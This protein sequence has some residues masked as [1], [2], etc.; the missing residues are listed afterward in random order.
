[1][2]LLHFRYIVDT[3]L[4]GGL[5]KMLMQSLW[6]LPIRPR[7]VSVATPDCS[8]EQI[9]TCGNTADKWCQC[10]W[11]LVKQPEVCSLS[12]TAASLSVPSAG[13]TRGG[14]VRVKCTGSSK[15]IKTL[16]E[17]SKRG[18]F[19][20]IFYLFSN[21]TLVSVSVCEIRSLEQEVYYKSGAKFRYIIKK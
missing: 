11:C 10:G 8:S 14:G 19:N 21:F 15:L 4:Q 9:S 16:C 3:G 12:L 6:Q 20:R 5:Q 1:M 7:D 2:K 17:R 13:I 18:Y